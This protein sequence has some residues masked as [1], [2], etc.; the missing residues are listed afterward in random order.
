[1]SSDTYH[2]FKATAGQADVLADFS[3]RT[4]R[5]AFELM[6][7]TR[8]LE[9]YIELHFTPEKMRQQLADRRSAVFIA[10]IDGFWVGYV[11][12]KAG[13]PPECVKGPKPLQLYRL[14]I[15]R[16]YQGKGLGQVL[17]KKCYAYAKDKGFK[18]LWLSTWVENTRAID[19]YRKQGFE[20][21][22]KQ[23]FWVGNDPQQDFI[24]AKI[25][26]GG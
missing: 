3:R 8:D 6:T 4:F 9:A 16:A 12:L 14:Y 21:A 18:T 1:M 19:V 13:T 25:L 24:M 26:P 7:D 20:T 22:G 15:S 2:I 10:E 5:E 23:I 17:M 11:H